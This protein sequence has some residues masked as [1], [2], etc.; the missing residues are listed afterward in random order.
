MKNKAIY[1]ETIK[2]WINSCSTGVQV[3]IATEAIETLYKTN[4][5]IDDFSVHLFT[6][7]TDKLNNLQEFDLVGIFGNKN[8]D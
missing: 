3:K 8:M 6:L 2:G 1:Y 7:A 5:G 4:F